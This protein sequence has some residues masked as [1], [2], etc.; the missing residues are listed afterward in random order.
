MKIEE[1]TDI[2]IRYENKV[3]RIAINRPDKLNAIRIRTYREL[4]SALQ[5]ADASS[6]I[7]TSS[8]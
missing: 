5:A 2:S 7:A 6:A 8:F 1:Y 3:A 4:I